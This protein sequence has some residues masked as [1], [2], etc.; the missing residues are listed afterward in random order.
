MRDLQVH[1][2]LPFWLN[3]YGLLLLHLYIMKRPPGD[4]TVFGRKT[5]FTTYKYNVGGLEYTLKDIEEG[6]VRSA[7]HK[8]FKEKD[9]RHRFALKTD[10]RAAFLLSLMTRSSPPLRIYTGTDWENVMWRCTQDFVQKSTRI[11][12]DKKR[13][14]LPSVAE[15]VYEKD[16]RGKKEELTMWISQFMGPDQKQQLEQLFS[17]HKK[18]SLSFDDFDWTPDPMFEEV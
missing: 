4:M 18:F 11:D 6:I 17:L 2:A 14:Y 16:F 12:L 13:I 5:F 1:E 15:E 9:A 10:P 7:V 3:L 8:G